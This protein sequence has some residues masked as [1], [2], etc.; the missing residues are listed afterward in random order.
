MFRELKTLTNDK[1]RI[2]KNGLVTVKRKGKANKGKVLSKGTAMIRKLLGNGQGSH[3]VNILEVTGNPVPDKNARTRTKA[4]SRQDAFDGTGTSST[5]FINLEQASLMAVG[6]TEN[7]RIKEAQAL[8]ITLA[9]ELKHALDNWEGAN[10]YFVAHVFDF[11]YNKE[12]ISI[13]YGEIKTRK[14]E[15]EIRKE[16]GYGANDMRIIPSTA[17]AFNSKY[18]SAINDFNKRLSKKYNVEFRTD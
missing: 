12:S 11:D 4:D 15:N 9:H 18:K 17:G 8:N 7:S 6:A 5:I 1:L 2:D 16:Q 3:M 10:N 13:T 14:F